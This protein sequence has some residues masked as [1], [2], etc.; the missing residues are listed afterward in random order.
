MRL[1]ILPLLAFAGFAIAEDD[2][3]RCADKNPSAVNAIGKFCQK[4]D[5]VIPSTYG[6]NGVDGYNR[7][8]H[9]DVSTL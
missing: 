8:T 6:N 4:T 1:L 5:L 3:G 7:K 2:E 9:V